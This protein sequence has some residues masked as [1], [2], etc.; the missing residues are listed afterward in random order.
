MLFVKECK[1]VL[2]SLVFWIYCLLAILMFLTNYFSDCLAE[3]FPPQPGLYAG[4]YGFKPSTDRDVIIESSINSLLNDYISNNYI[5]YPFGFYKAVHLKEKDKKKIENYITEITNFDSKK[6]E[7]IQK[8][9]KEYYVT[10]GFNEYKEYQ[11][12]QFAFNTNNVTYERFLEIMDDIDHILGGGSEYSAESVEFTFSMIPMTYED[13][14]NDYNDL[15]EKD[16]ISKGYARL[17]SDYLGIVLSIVPVFVAVSMVTAD[18]RNNMQDLIL[19]RKIS[20]YK[21]IFTRFFALVIMMFIPV[22]I[23]MI[24]AFIQLQILYH[25]QEISL[26]GM[27]TLPSFWLIPNI[28]MSTAIGM[29]FSEIFSGG[30][31]II[32]QFMW[33]FISLIKGAS[34]LYG[35]IEKSTFICRH[36]TIY[37][38][39]IFMS[40]INN[41]I[42]NRIFYI[43][44]SLIAILLTAYIYELKR[45]GKF[46]GIKLFGKGGILRHKT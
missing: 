19:S 11:V 15:F 33:W 24:I 21:L 4:E 14:L 45:G 26:S 1:K 35:K 8:N 3:E 10:E 5:C 41:F 46:N 40:E 44:L 27:F 31:A 18:K 9:S 23:S 42:F 34:S 36:N 39:S 13:S 28:S 6:I 7:E 30:T 32:A 37:E 20:N 12:D 16:K 2:K 17:F 38:R 29:L 25:G 43:I 22:I